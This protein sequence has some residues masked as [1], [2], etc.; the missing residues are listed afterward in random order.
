MADVD[1]VIVGGGPAGAAVALALKD[2]GVSV[3][4]LEAREGP[5]SLADQRAIALS[6]GSRLILQRLGAWQSLGAVTPIHAIHV[7]SRGSFGRA[8]ITPKDAG[9]PALGYVV[10]YQDLWAALHGQIKGSGADYFTGVKVSRVESASGE[11]GAVEFNYRGE[12]RKITAR[13][14]VVA[15]GGP[16]VGTIPGISQRVRDYRQWAVMAQVETDRPHGNAAFE[17]FTAEGPLALLPQAERL[18]LVWTLPQDGAGEMLDLDDENFLAR[19]HERFGDR[20]GNF[21]RTTKRTGLPLTL[22]YAVPVIAEHL[23][24]IGNAA[25]LLHPVAGQGFNVGL[26]D[27]WELADEILAAPEAVGSGRML[28]R[29]QGRRRFDR[30]SA[31]LFTDSLVQL[32]SNANPVL[33]PARAAGLSLLDCVPSAKSFLGRR[34]IFGTKG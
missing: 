27:A 18:A 10:N 20:L 12:P 9:V 23:V 25:Q 1:I 4:I 7:S 33:G 21:I 6:H 17:R 19:L 32:F 8:L 30:R 2:S 13:L 3:L 28:G 31:I 29:Y 15:D 22:K 24:L 26:R 34:M 5:A 16:L 11:G 14:V